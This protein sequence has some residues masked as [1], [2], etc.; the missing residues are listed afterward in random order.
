L[1]RNTFLFNSFD[2]NQL[3]FIVL[4][5]FH[6][7]SSGSKEETGCPPLFSMAE[8]SASEDQ[9]KVD[10]V[11][12]EEELGTFQILDRLEQATEASASDDQDKV[13]PVKQEEE[14]GTFQILDRLE[15]A[16]E[17]SASDDQAVDGSVKQEEELGIF[18]ILDKLEQVTDTLLSR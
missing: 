17:A 8:A 15:Q 18:Q 13:D 11:K 12:Q 4:F 2:T 6:E 10:P 14:L 3:Y 9:D 7:E 5:S 1:C 16:I